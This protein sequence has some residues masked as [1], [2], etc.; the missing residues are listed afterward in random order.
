MIA[1]IAPEAR[2]IDLA[3]GP[4]DLRGAAAVLA[5]SVPHAPPEAVHLA[6]IDPGVGTTRRPVALESSSGA[7]FV[8]PDNG[9]LLEAADVLGGVRRAVELADPRYRPEEVSA[10]FHGRDVFAPAAAHLAAGVGLGDLGPAVDPGSLVRLAEPHV[11]VSSGRLV[12]D[13]LRT[14]HF[15]NVQLAAGAGDLEGAALGERVLVR[16]GGREVEA[17]R[18]TT[19]ADAPEGGLVV[20]LDSAG[21][22]AVAV[23]GGDAWTA[24]GHPERLV[25]E[26][27]GGR[28]EVL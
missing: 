19:F 11:E 13:V 20:H 5:Q 27:R 6:V 8:G 21:R 16:G 17:V 14:D 1:R 23:R 9:V 10:T 24:L 3:H 22:V 15:G 28:Q 4:R 25:L 7:L 26:R 2:V 18:G 12:A